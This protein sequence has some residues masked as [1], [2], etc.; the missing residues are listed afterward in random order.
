MK[1]SVFLLFFAL[2]IIASFNLTGEYWVKHL[3]AGDRQIRYEAKTAAFLSLN[4]EFTIFDIKGNIFR[5]GIFKRGNREWLELQNTISLDDGTFFS[6]AY[7]RD[8][9]NEI[10]GY[11]KITRFSWLGEVLFVK[12]IKIDPQLFQFGQLLQVGDKI[13]LLGYEDPGNLIGNMILLNFTK[14]GEL[15]DFRRLG[16][17]V[18]AG[19]YY[20][21]ES[22]FIKT[23]DD[24][25]IIIKTG[26]IR[27]GNTLFK[28]IHLMKFAGNDELVISKSYYNPDLLAGNFETP[29]VREDPQNGYILLLVE[30]ISEN[31]TITRFPHLFKFD[32]NWQLQWS[33]KYLAGIQLSWLK[34]VHLLPD[35]DFYTI[36]L[37]KKVT[38][39]VETYSTPVLMRT[40]GSGVV[41]WGKTYEYGGY[42]GISDLL[43]INNGGMLM[44]THNKYFYM[45]DSSGEVPGDCTVVQEISFESSE[46]QFT[47]K[48][49][50]ND[51][52]ITSFV[53]GKTTDYTGFFYE[54]DPSEIG[55]DETFCQYPILQG[56]FYSVIER[57]RFSGYHIHRVS[58]SL[59]PGV[60]PFIAKVHVYRKF[61][62]EVSDY[63]FI[64][65]VVM[66]ENQTDYQVEY[67]PFVLGKSFYNYKIMAYNQDNELV[68]YA[69]LQ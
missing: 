49:L 28:G 66:V 5:Q 8:E 38:N 22:T 64:S 15:L 20:S 21:A 62:D 25:Y 1:K 4:P 33:K 52:I 32:E 48:P 29:V 61:S 40:D 41:S 58:F 3:A 11:Y 36:G 12:G 53:P 57:S 26:D 6:L 24:H 51:R 46:T 27:V 50:E 56:D 65:E 69:F 45:L 2:L 14:D 35:R 60:V 39:G 7:S 55:G 54:Y 34:G 30:R 16:L 18:K 17:N 68:D 9:N 31:E 44:S 23:R 37:N 10:I 67:S 42:R 47:E 19:R 63:E 13:K 59:D 43:T